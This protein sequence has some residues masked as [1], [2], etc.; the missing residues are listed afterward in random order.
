MLAQL[1]YTPGTN[2]TNYKAEGMGDHTG[3][4]VIG[5]PDPATSVLYQRAIE[6]EFTVLV[7]ADATAILHALHSHTVA[8]LVVE[9]ALF[10]ANGWEQLEVVSRACIRSGVPL[11]ICSTQDERRKGRDLGAVAYLIKPTLPTTLI[12]T[13]RQVLA[14]AAT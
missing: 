9:P 5:E 13:I 7:A 10:G 4:V 2:G 1:D 12:E 11:V 6:G 3:I 8:V 14:G